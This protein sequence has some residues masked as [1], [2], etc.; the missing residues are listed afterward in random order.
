MKILANEL[1]EG[2]DVKYCNVWIYINSLTNRTQKNGK[3]IICVSGVSY[4]GII[5]RDGFK[6]KTESQPY[7][8]EF[9]ESTKVQVR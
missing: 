6:I 2:E 7:N 5:K 8:C 3:N 9:K 1:K 4:S